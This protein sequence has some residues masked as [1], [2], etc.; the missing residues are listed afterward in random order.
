MVSPRVLSWVQCSLASGSAINCT[1]GKFAD[2][3]KLSGTVHMIEG[4]DAIQTDLDRLEKWAYVNQMKFNRAK[5][6]VFAIESV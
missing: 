5:C 4:K 1:L 6:K 2:D 3:T